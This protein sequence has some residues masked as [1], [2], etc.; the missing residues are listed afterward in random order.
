MAMTLSFDNLR[1][2]TN[3]T[4]NLGQ[5]NVDSNGNISKI[6]N[7]KYLTFLNGKDADQQSAQKIK[8]IIT[9]A[10]LNKTDKAF[11]DEISQLLTKDSEQAENHGS[12]SREVLKVAIDKIDQQNQLYRTLTDNFTPKMAAKLQVNND[13]QFKTNTNNCCKEKIQ[14]MEKVVRKVADEVIRSGLDSDCEIYKDFLAKA[15]DL[16]AR[17]S[18][19]DQ[20][21]VK[22]KDTPDVIQQCINNNK[23]YLS[24]PENVN[25]SQSER[26]DINRQNEEFAAKLEDDIKTYH[27]LVKDVITLFTPPENKNL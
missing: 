23:S 14:M 2:L 19:L 16:I 5:I 4:H 21:W 3:G 18:N 9:G 10:I 22:C 7:H 17:I 12:I 11:F 24:C 8:G 26:D 6:N 25:I 1:T 20:R 15:R 27:D 13:N